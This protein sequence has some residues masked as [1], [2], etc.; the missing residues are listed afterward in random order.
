MTRELKWQL[1]MSGNRPGWRTMSKIR[2][3]VDIIKKLNSNNTRFIHCTVECCL[4]LCVPSVF[5][6]HHWSECECHSWMQFEVR[7]CRMVL[8][9]KTAV[10]WGLDGSRCRLQQVFFV[11]WDNLGLFGYFFLFKDQ[12][13]KKVFSTSKR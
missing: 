12:T 9:E 2:F 13:N 1:N 4:F 3:W 10:W 7:N 6:Q 5:T 11:I 8:K